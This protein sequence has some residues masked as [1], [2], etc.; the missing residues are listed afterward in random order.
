MKILLKKSLSL[1]IVGILCSSCKGSS[2]KTIDLTKLHNSNEQY[3]IVVFRPMFFKYTEMMERFTHDSSSVILGYPNGSNEVY[4]YAKEMEGKK[5]QDSI[6]GYQVGGTWHSTEED[7]ERSKLFT[8][9]RGEGQPPMYRPELFYTVSM[10]PAGNYYINRTMF[11][12]GGVSFSVEKNYIENRYSKKESPFYFSVQAGKINYLGDL[13]FFSPER[14]NYFLSTYNT[15][16]A[17]ID[18][19]NEAKDYMKLFY[20]QLHL[21]FITNFI[22]KTS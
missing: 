5:A 6:F 19:A 4:V 17:L 16:V 14:I 9:S 2:S 15:N 8:I 21:P 22:R 7:I 10:I 13:Y 18:K 11:N 12:F 3:G 1:I 20:P